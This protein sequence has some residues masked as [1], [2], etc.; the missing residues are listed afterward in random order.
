MKKIFLV[1]LGVV[2]VF[3][4]AVSTVMY[5][6]F[7]AEKGAADKNNRF[8]DCQNRVDTETQMIYVK[9]SKIEKIYHLKIDELDAKVYKEGLLID[10]CNKDKE[11]I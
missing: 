1:F 3:I 9:F 7:M 4:I 10:S 5:F 8:Q 6:F 2:V 11:K